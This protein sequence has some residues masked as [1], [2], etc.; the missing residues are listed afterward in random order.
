MNMMD[1]TAYHK[2]NA[3]ERHSLAGASIDHFQVHIGLALALQRLVVG[4]ALIKVVSLAALLV[5]VV[6][7]QQAL[8]ALAAEEPAAKQMAAELLQAWPA[9]SLRRVGQ[10]NGWAMIMHA[11][12]VTSCIC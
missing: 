6:L 12:P 7:A 11:G 5:G 1:P 2:L 9:S 4:V 10:G 8:L 3:R